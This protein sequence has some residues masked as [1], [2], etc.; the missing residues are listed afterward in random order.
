MNKM[1]E[2]NKDNNET[3]K[4]FKLLD[5]KNDVVFQMLFLKDNL[6]KGLLENILSD[7]ITSLRV[8]VNKQLFGNTPE[9]KIG[10]VDLRAVINEEIECEIEMQMFYFKNFI[11]RFLDYW[12][13]LYS[14]QLKK[15]DNYEL[16]HK[17]VSIAIINQNIPNLKDLQAH[18]I[19]HIREDG[20]H[21]KI[22]TNNLEL[23]II[24]VQKVKKEYKN[25]KDDKLLQWIMFLLNP[26]SEEVD[27]IMVKNKKIEEAKKELLSL[28]QDEGNQRIADFRERE[29]RDKIDMYE[30]GKDIGKAEG[31]KV[32]KAEG[33][34]VGKAEGIKEGKVE[35]IINLL[36]MKMPIDKIMQ[37]TKMTKEEIEKIRKSKLL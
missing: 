16:L 13:K 3:K 15:G 35:V 30:T 2:N 31:I 18:T 27:N 5:P 32:G 37:A 1:I 22:L 20:N 25:N 24:E 33:I 9:D 19:W 28:S 17:A 36:N 11:P 21:R 29:L 4:E 23:H 6:A 8:D 14:G 10:I 7:N 34:K 26:E 12:S